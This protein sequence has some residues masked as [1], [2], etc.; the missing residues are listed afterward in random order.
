MKA[1]RVNDLYW[2]WSGDLRLGNDGDLSE[3]FPNELQSFIQEV[4]TRLRSELYDWQLHP[5][6]GASLVDLIGRPN[7]RETAE[8]G[9]AHIIAALTK[10]GFVSR[11][12]IGVQYSPVDVDQLLYIVRISLPDVTRDEVLKF[13]LLFNIKSFG[14]TFL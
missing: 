10:D 11:S 5:H 9:K 13:S 4:Q 3:T 7:N 2:T 8:A 14:V 12:L 6:L 1:H